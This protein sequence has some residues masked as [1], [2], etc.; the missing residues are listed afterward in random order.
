[1]RVERGA[2]EELAVEV[3]HAGGPAGG[4]ADRGE[5]LGQQ[6][7]E[8]RSFGLAQLGFQLVPFFFELFALLAVLI[9]QGPRSHGFQAGAHVAGG[10][11][12]TALELVGLGPQSLR[13]EAGKV[14]LEAVDLRY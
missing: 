7:V 3:T 14:R 12:D 10:L 13:A 4:L 1:A 5:R 9:T 8:D 6:R 2:G 11:L